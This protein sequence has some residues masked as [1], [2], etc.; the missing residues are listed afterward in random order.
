MRYLAAVATSE[1]SK[2]VAWSSNTN[3]DQMVGLSAWLGG[4]SWSFEETFILG[5][6][7]L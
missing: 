2:C 6:N 3:G 4:L 1:P 5:G 7:N